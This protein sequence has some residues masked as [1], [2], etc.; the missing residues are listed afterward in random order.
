MNWRWNS[1]KNTITG[2]IMIRVAAAIS[3][4]SCVR[5]PLNR[6]RPVAS[7]RLS[8][9]RQVQ[10]RQQ[11]R[12]PGRHEREDRERRGARQRERDHDP[13]EDADL[14]AAVDPGGVGEL[15]RDVEEE[16][17]HQEDAERQAPCRRRRRSTG[18]ITAIGVFSRPKSRR[19]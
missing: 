10:Q 6:S 5:P 12:V 3:S 4:S 14:V 13:A 18:R 15:A 9:A 8:V 7:V 1:R 17:P 19:S 16:R 2:A 11:E